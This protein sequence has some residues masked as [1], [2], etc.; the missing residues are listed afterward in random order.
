VEVILRM[1]AVKHLY[2]FSYEQTEQHVSD[3]LVLRQ[4]CRV[5]FHAVPDHTTLC[6]W[7]RLIKPA[8]LASV[9]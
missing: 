3:S 6:R 8:T 9:Q 2:D 5:Y 1:L 4:F 7:A